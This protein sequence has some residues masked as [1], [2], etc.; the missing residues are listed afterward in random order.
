MSVGE[1]RLQRKGSLAISVSQVKSFGDSPNCI[2]PGVSKGQV[3]MSHGVTG[4]QVRGFFILLN[5]CVESAVVWSRPQ[6]LGRLEGGKGSGRLR[7]GQ[8]S[9]TPLYIRK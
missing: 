4:I 9:L 7:S 1:T 6:G 5:C 2:E 3:G 8:L